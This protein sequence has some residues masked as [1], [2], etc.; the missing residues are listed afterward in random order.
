MGIPHGLLAEKTFYLKVES[1]VCDEKFKAWTLEAFKQRHPH[2]LVTK[3]LKDCPFVNQSASWANYLAN[4]E[5]YNR[6]YSC[7]VF[8]TQ[9]NHANEQMQLEFQTIKEFNQV[10][11]K[12][13]MP[14]LQFKQ[15]YE[16]NMQEKKA[17]KLL[18]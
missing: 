13:F 2:L 10:R 3:Q 14:F 16:L 6:E 7:S 17:P 12:E 8:N 9:F 1:K 4:Q 18:K 11:G 5:R 15:I